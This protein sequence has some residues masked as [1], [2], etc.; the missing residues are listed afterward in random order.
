GVTSVPSGSVVHDAALFVTPPAAKLSGTLTYAFYGTPDGSGPPIWTQDQNY[1]SG[2]AGTNPLPESQP[3]S[4]LAPGSY[5]FQATFQG[6]GNDKPFHLIG[7]VEPLTVTGNT[8]QGSLT[9][10]TTPD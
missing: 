10:S 8:E 3:T 2:N 5:S 1:N 7:A 6:S 4:T 9:L